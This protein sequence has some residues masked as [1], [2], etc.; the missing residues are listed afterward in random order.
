MSATEIYGGRGRGVGPPATWLISATANRQSEEALV[1][2]ERRRIWVS[3]LGP[4]GH[5]EIF[6]GIGHSD[7]AFWMKTTA[8]HYATELA[9]ER[10]PSLLN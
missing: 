6:G 5:A 10:G 2:N 1:K 4:V 8:Q 7:E 9:K 3:I